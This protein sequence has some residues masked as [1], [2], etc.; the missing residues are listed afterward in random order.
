[1][2]ITIDPKLILDKVKQPRV[3]GTAIL[4]VLL[5]VGVAWW[6]T[7]REKRIK[8]SIIQRDILIT[9]LNNKWL[10]CLN[11]PADTVYQTITI[12]SGQSQIIKPKPERIFGIYDSTPEK[13]PS[14]VTK[15]TLADD[16]PKG[17]YNDTIRVDKFRVNLEA[18]GCIRSMRILSVG[19]DHNYMIVTKNHT[20]IQYD[21]IF[22]DKP[23]PLLRIGPYAG[24]TLN[25]FN[26]FP[27]F[28]LGGQAII[29][30]Q[31]TVSVGAL[32]IDGLYGNVRIGILFKK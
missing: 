14:I 26:V 32:Y 15:E 25:S 28:E 27:G 8:N 7:D 22:K 20:V 1:M 2:A 4:V 3:W 31:L 6:W 21:T 16:C 17:Y 13:P 29:K 9:Q 10:L 23:S 11:A 30:D 5:I 12:T 24:V 18:I 19:L